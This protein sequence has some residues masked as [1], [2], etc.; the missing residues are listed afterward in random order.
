MSRAIALLLLLT[1]LYAHEWTQTPPP[2]QPPTVIRAGILIDADK[3]TVA[4]DQ[5]IVVQAGKITAVGA[6]LEI[7]PDATIIDLSRY[8]VL[9][10][11]F[12]AHTHLCMDLN[13]QRDA[14]RYFHTTLQDP[15][16]VRAIQGVVHARSLLKAGFTTVRDIGNEGNYACS[17][18][19]RA[20]E[21]G[22]F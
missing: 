20:I 3:G 14:G 21:T 17:S 16:A 7:P 19:R 5:M 11:L 9:P 13:L 4:T 2:V 22:F 1:S 8:S 6:R 18:V 12:D 10:G 15:N